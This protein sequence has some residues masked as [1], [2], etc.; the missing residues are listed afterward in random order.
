M[1]VLRTT[2]KQANMFIIGKQKL[3]SLNNH[4]KQATRTWLLGIGTII[5]PVSGIG[6]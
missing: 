5:H 1:K 4:Y 2:R 6:R 3:L